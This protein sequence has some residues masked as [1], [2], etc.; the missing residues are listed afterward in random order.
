MVE[1][2]EYQHCITGSVTKPQRTSIAHFHRAWTRVG[3]IDLH[4]TFANL[5]KSSRR[6]NQMD[7]VAKGGKPEGIWT[8]AASDIGHHGGRG[9]QI[10]LHNYLRPLE[11]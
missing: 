4:S 9:R 10:S 7:F 6:V 1:R 11:F 3:W 2:S 5:H 8:G